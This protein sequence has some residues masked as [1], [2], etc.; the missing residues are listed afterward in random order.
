M[1][2]RIDRLTQAIHT[3]A[4]TQR[5]AAEAAPAAREAGPART[6]EPP[7]LLNPPSADLLF[8]S[9][10]LWAARAYGLWREHRAFA[11]LRPLAG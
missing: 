3:L 6:A 11:R 8:L 9:L 2:R 7:A 10:G 5:A 4:A 1:L